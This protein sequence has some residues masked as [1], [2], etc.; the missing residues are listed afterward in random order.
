METANF[1]KIKET[2]LYPFLDNDIKIGL[3]IYIR[4]EIERQS[5]T[6]AFLKETFSKDLTFEEIVK[7]LNV[8]LAWELIERTYEEVENGKVSMIYRLTDIGRNIFAKE[9]QDVLKKIKSPSIK[10]TLRS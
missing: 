9:Y 7:G 1:E 5:A 4:N 3:A 8:L 6:L 2:E 10:P